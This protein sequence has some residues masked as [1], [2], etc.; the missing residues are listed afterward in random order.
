MIS[1]THITAACLALAATTLGCRSGAEE[2][3][4]DTPSHKTETASA[5]P[6]RPA[7]AAKPA[8]SAGPSGP[9]SMAKPAEASKPADAK[10]SGATK[11]ADAKPMNPNAADTKPMEA[12]KSDSGS[13][14]DGMSV[15]KIGEAAPAFTLKDMD[16]KEHS[17]A[18]YKGKTVVLEW[19]NPKCPVCVAA[20]TDGSLK[21]MPE[22]IMADGV[23]WLGINS[24]SPE[25]NSN[26]EVNRPFMEKHNMKAPMLVDTTGAVGMSYGAKTTPHMY[27]IDAKGVLVYAGAIDNK[28]EKGAALV[29]YVDAAL[30]DMKAGTAVKIKE[31]KPYGCSVKYGKPQ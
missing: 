15:A 21:G 22:R 3:Q 1:R 25:S 18:Q 4:T 11:P 19:F 26:G 12:K 29:N 9:S 2:A 6:S 10:P 13:K 7:K 28:Q 17:L 27:V 31:T 23:V 24:G 20:Y 30:A 14:T 8:E 5:G 16:G